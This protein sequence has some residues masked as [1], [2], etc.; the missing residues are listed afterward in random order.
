MACLKALVKFKFGFMR[1]VLLRFS[2]RA[3]IFYRRGVKFDGGCGVSIAA[4]QSLHYPFQ[5]A[6][7]FIASAGY[8]FLMN[9][10]RPLPPFSKSRAVVLPERFCGLRV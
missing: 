3:S 1:G 6:S 8:L 4:D 7:R 9:Y 10:A 5:Q 2:R